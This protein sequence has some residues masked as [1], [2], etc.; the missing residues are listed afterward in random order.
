[1]LKE[2][3]IIA[4]GLLGLHGYPLQVHFAADAPNA[5]APSAAVPSTQPSPRCGGE[6][7]SHA[8]PACR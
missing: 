4:T 2:L 8:M 1:M 3:R 6:L 7:P 5:T